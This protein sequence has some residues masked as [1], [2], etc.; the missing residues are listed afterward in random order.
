MNHQNE[1]NRLSQGEFLLF[2]ELLLR[3]T[4]MQI[5]SRRSQ[6]MGRHLWRVAAQRGMANLQVLYE[7]L[8]ETRTESDLWD[9]VISGLTI[10]ETYFFR[11]SSQFEALRFHLLPEIIKRRRGERRL[12]LW[13]AGCAS[14]EEPYSLAML[15]TEIIPDLDRWSISILGTDI[16]K[17]SL[18]RARRGRYKKWS[19]RQVGPDMVRRFFTQ[20]N[21]RFELHLRIKSMV[22]FTYLNL[23]E[24]NYPSLMTNTCAMDLI[25]CRN[26][27]IYLPDEQVQAMVRRFAGCLTQ[28]GWLMVAATETDPRGFAD[29]I[30]RNM[31]SA[32][33]YQL[34][35]S[36][37]NQ[38]QTAWDLEACPAAKEPEPIA[39]EIKTPP[40][41]PAAPPVLRPPLTAGPDVL[42]QARRM[43]E[44][45]RYQSARCLLEQ[46]KGN[47]RGTSNLW[48]KGARRLANL[49]KLAEASYWCEK[50][51]EAEPLS[52][53][54]HHCRALIALE[55]GNPLL[56]GDH[57][58]KALYLEPNHL[59]AHFSLATLYR[60]MGE[61]QKALLHGRQA[62]RLASSLPPEQSV[63]EADGLAAGR[64]VTMLRV[65]LDAA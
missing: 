40:P 13:S 56:A 16:N 41:R 36:E 18:A 64:I 59:A 60:R 5:T 9:Q 2:H 22:N 46:A 34:R 8:D 38:A 49:G 10:G 62:I 65:L 32:A 3:R 54:G 63:P 58:R 44:T 30:T 6:E 61:S 17:E 19:F 47:R 52:A 48:L 45:D 4:G 53:E 28:S 39:P 25:L 27:A 35:S 43:M 42:S 57:L 24:D 23:S 50:S 33:V 12:R 31:G 51:L 37:E 26:V 15:L 1:N 21:D 29:F 55:E 14:G 11:D 20:E 7:R